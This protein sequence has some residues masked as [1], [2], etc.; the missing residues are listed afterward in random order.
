MLML[1][2][3]K[4]TMMNAL[5]DDADDGNSGHDGVVVLNTRPN[6]ESEFAYENGVHLGAAF[7]DANTR[8]ARANGAVSIRL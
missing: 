3:M 7:R 2:M 4:V 6:H 8:T 1:M 5:Y